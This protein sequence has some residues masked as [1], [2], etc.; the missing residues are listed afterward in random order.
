MKKITILLAIAMLVMVGC[1]KK[2]AVTAGGQT[3]TIRTQEEQKEQ[4]NQTY[5]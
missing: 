2:E 3:M 4:V 1:K 5:A